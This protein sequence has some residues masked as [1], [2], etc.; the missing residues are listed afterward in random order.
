MTRN[1]HF[2]NKIA[3]SRRERG[4][5]ANQAR[6]DRAANTKPGPVHSFDASLKSIEREL[7]HTPR[8]RA[9]KVTLPKLSI[10]GDQ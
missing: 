3:R 8:P 7:E 5:V 6:S 2:L 1:W 4:F 10:L 9:A